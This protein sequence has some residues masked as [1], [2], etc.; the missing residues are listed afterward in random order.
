MRAA[1]P[2]AGS[3]R[4]S[5][6]ALRSSAATAS[7]AVAW[8]TPSSRASAVT[9]HQ[10]LPEICERHAICVGVRPSGSA[11][12]HALMR[13]KPASCPNPAAI[14]SLSCSMVLMRFL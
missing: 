8:V 11:S 10:P 12:R 6:S 14:C 13:R 1:R 2:S 3:R 7:L 4:R 5:T 9:R